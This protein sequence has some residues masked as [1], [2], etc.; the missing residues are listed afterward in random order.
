METRIVRQ[1]VRRELATSKEEFKELDEHF[2]LSQKWPKAY[3]SL[4]NETSEHPTPCQQSSGGVVCVYMVDSGRLL[5]AEVGIG[6]LR[7]NFWV[8]IP[9]RPS[10]SSTTRQYSGTIRMYS[11]GVRF[12][13]R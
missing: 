7:R 13:I 10:Y 4:S 6:P 8:I 9:N 5:E 11:F 3:P 1:V 2:R 12:G